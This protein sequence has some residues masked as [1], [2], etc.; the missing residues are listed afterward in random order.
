M[1]AELPKL[2]ATSK[3][4]GCRFWEIRSTATQLPARERNTLQKFFVPVA[5]AF[6]AM[7]LNYRRHDAFGDSDPRV[8]TWEGR[9]GPVGLEVY[10]REVMGYFAGLKKDEQELAGPRL[11]SNL[12]GEAKLAVQDLD[13]TSLR[14]EKGVEMLLSRLAERFPETT[15]KSVPRAYDK[16]FEETTFKQDM[17]LYLMEL[18]IAQDELHKADPE[19][20]ISDTT[21]GYICLKNSNLTRLSDTT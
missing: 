1:V 9:K 20:K 3:S 11:W 19:S 10:R 16:L 21:M 14:N 17:N 15:L 6:A 8:P 5:L 4:S 2:A 18:A 12:R 13:P 7:A